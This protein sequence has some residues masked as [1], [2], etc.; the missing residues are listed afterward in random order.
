MTA[1]I[2]VDPVIVATPTDDTDRDGIIA[3]L[4]NLELWLKEALSAHFL[5][6]HARNITEQL[7]AH[8]YLPTFEIL[9]TWAKR[10]RLDIN[11]TLLARD[12][13]T[14]FREPKHDL[15]NQLAD[16]GYMETGEPV[17]IEP[18]Q[19][20]ARWPTFMY[21]NMCNL[22]VTC[23]VCKYA[24]HPFAN[25]LHIATMKLSDHCQEMSISAIIKDSILEL[26]CKPG[27]IIAQTF[28]LL[29]TPEHL[30][31][32]IDVLAGRNRHNLCH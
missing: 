13:H 20:V 26:A 18:E 17:T 21:T 4:H 25:D 8:G 14:F 3:W 6:L 7:E 10:Y 22:L 5:W 30:Q 12:I 15:E 2:F 23:S 28:P 19:I 32:L 11:P 1:N 27:D 29:F 24:V 31:P 9:R 16:L